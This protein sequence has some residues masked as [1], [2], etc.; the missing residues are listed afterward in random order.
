MKKIQVFSALSIALG[1]AS[2]VAIPPAAAQEYPT[3]PIKLIMPFAP[4][5]ATDLFARSLSE[6]MTE[7][8]GQPVILDYK[9]GAA[10][11]LANEYVANA[12]KDGYTLLVGTTG[13]ALNIIMYGN[14]RYKMED[15]APISVIAV[16]AFSMSVSKKLPVSTAKDFVE[17]AR[18][19]PGQL[20][21]GTL[22]SG[23][24]PHLLGEMFEEVA[25][26]DMVDVPYKGSGPALA[27]LMSGDVQLYFDSVTSSIPQ[28]RGGTIGILGLTSEN[29]LEALPEMPT[30]DEQ[31]VPLIATSWFGILAPAGTPRPI[32]E[33]LNREINKAVASDEYQTRLN[34]AGATP[35]A[36]ESPEKFAELIESMTELWGRIPRRLNI[37]FD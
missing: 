18:A 1:A 30:L 19:R 2:M 35:M 8:M 24:T 6:R 31:D 4:G 33:K 14:V 23:S 37:K 26:V 36:S 32:I 7:S 21:Y 13:M 34:T 17:Y 22:G 10:S 29:R 3:R 11:I 25:G 5:G 27:A 9:P 15:F 20:N 16:P 12:P 28:Y